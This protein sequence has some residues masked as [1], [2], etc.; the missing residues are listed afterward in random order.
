MAF[1]DRIKNGKVFGIIWWY[2]LWPLTWGVFLKG[3]Y[4]ARTVPNEF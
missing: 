1:R 3:T 2:F 4:N